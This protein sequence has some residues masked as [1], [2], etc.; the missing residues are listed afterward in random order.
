MLHY[1]AAKNGGTNGKASSSHAS[2]CS[3]VSNSRT[4]MTLGIP[5][6][7]IGGTSR[8]LVHPTVPVRT[9][10]KRLK[11]QEDP[12]CVNAVTSNESK[13]CG[14]QQRTKRVSYFFFSNYLLLSIRVTMTGNLVSKFGPQEP[15][16]LFVFGNGPIKA[17]SLPKR[18]HLKWAGAQETQ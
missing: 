8:Y 14:R 15:S 13:E 17:G 4:R 9:F 12:P 5:K 10:P 16:Y 3:F 6:H 7:S 1:V 2:T 18:K 11:M